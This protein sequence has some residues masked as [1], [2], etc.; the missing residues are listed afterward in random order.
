MADEVRITRRVGPR[1]LT[2]GVTLLALLIVFLLTRNSPSTEVSYLNHG[3]HATYVGKQACA[4]CHAEKLASFSQTG[5]GQSFDRATLTKSAAT[6]TPHT[7]VRDT[8]TGYSYHPFWRSDSLF[9]REFRLYNGDTTYQQEVYIKYIVGSGQHTNSHILEQNGYLFQA[10]ITYYVQEN[11]WDLAPGFE[12]GNNSRFDRMLNTECIS[13]HN[14]MPKTQPGSPFKFTE[15]GHGIDCERCHGPGS[16]HAEARK[17][18]KA[19][20]G[21]F[22]P[23][24][25]NPRDLS[26]ERQIDVCQR[27][28]LQGLNLLKEG[29]RFEDFRPGMVLSDYFDIYLPQ[30]AGDQT[31]LDMANHAQR[32]QMSMCFTQQKSNE[33]TCISC[34]NPHFSVKY[35]P[36]QTY[37][38]ACK[39][40]HGPKDCTTA[41]ADRKKEEDDCVK[42]HMPAVESV[43][44]SHVSVHDHYI[45]KPVKAEEVKSIKRLIGLYAVNNTNPD[46]QEEVR[47]Y[48]EY[49]EKFDKNPFYLNRAKELLTDKMPQALWLKYYYLKEDYAKAMLYHTVTLDWSAWDHFML[50]Y[51]YEKQGRATQAEYHYAQAN[52]LDP[53]NLRIAIKYIARLIDNETFVQAEDQLKTSLV[54]FPRSAELHA[55]HAKLQI[56]R[57]QLNMAHTSLEKAFALD[58]LLLQ[59]WEAY[60][61]YGLRSGDAELAHR[62]AQRIVAKYPDHPQRSVIEL[63][64]KDNR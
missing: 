36:Q 44:I 20:E 28:H 47:A 16:V 18:N 41:L 25:V 21:S 56:T 10:P 17:N 32:F 4:T 50:A 61:N 52:S 49:W 30:Y 39:N 26:L 59:V 1:Y 48:M 13:C 34:H 31:E 57:G 2:L 60:L 53:T 9:I 33:F 51:S 38:A 22:D 45:R 37:N 46:P 54:E 43:D 35:T 8:A 12:E 19:F 6:F 27:C 63:A 24:I 5:M 15:I 11:R 64:I 29:K 40:C 62:W 55:L 14:A 58:P 3:E 42:C 7:V 23:T